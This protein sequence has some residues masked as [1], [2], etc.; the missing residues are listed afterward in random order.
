[1]C[2]SLRPLL[3]L[4]GLLPL[5]AA[6]ADVAVQRGDLSVTV[7]RA[8]T[9]SS[10][11]LDLNDLGGF[12]LVTE[13]RR[14]TIPAG[15]SRIRFENV[16]DGI[17]TA[18]VIITGLPGNVLERN[19]DARLLS[20][21][22]LV[23]AALGRSVMLARTN[24]KT[25]RQTR[26]FAKIRA[27]A[28][29]GVLFETPEGVEALRCSG[30]PETFGFITNTELAA[31]PTLSARVHS[32]TAAT[33]KVTLSYLARGF[34]WTATYVA[35]LS[36]EQNSM[37]LG[38]WVTLANSNGVAFPS[39]RTQI[40]A[41]RVNHATDTLEPLDLGEP[42]LAECWHT[43][44]SS[45]GVGADTTESII[46]TAQR[47]NTEL[48]MP[49]PMA[50]MEA[51]TT[52]KLLVQ[53]EQLGDLKLYRV[54]ERT[55]LKSRQIKQVRLLDRQGIPIDLYYGADLQ[56]NSAA[57]S[58]AARRTLRTKNDAAHHL[59][60]PLPSG[61]VASFLANDDAKLLLDETPLRDIALNEEFELG[62]GSSTDVQVRAVIEKTTAYNRPPFLRGV[63]RL[64]SAFVDDVNRVEIH[65]A[66]N[67]DIQFELRLHLPDGA[68]LIGAD[69]TATTRDGRPLFKLTVPANRTVTVRYQTEHTRSS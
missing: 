33:A 9:Q 54:P 3:A 19:R 51:A 60:L 50:M 22:A 52:A 62:A 17:E 58:A 67:T 16:A 36:P 27:A 18:S 53:E 10:E 11:P 12:A 20:P 34:D 46:V 49:V 29:G 38:A 48:M 56:A 39:A 6:A 24:L 15:E 13:T 43:G 32:P 41:G 55:T 21:A 4:L 2:P 14:V 1:M 5:G 64:K 66:G 35:T 45:E 44:N 59:G 63:M 7:Y 31:A 26:V 23:A 47:R 65:N 8:P 25:G 68:Q 61:H 30:L 42:I 37:D 28:D 69:A 40:V 57:V